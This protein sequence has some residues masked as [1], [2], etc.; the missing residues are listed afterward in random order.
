M[1][2]ELGFG[3][4]QSTAFVLG[5]P[6]T[7]SFPMEPTTDFVASVSHSP[8][9]QP[10]ALP[11]PTTASTETSTTPGNAPTSSCFNVE[12]S[13]LFDNYSFGKGFVIAFADSGESIESF[14][15]RDNSLANQLYTQSVC[16]PEGK[17]KF[18]IHDNY[19]NGLCCANGNGEYVVMNEEG[20][21]IANGGEFQYSEEVFFELP[22][23]HGQ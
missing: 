8:T 2:G 1:D 17:Y 11:P 21:I 12:I 16:L 18:T 23:L 19:G 5:P 10:V 7:S 4:S 13:I 20:T 9:F 6:S 22:F 3:A 15:P 14:F